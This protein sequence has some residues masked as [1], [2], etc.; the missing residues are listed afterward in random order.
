MSGIVVAEWHLTHDETDHVL[1]SGLE[2]TPQEQN[3]LNHLRHPLR[4]RQ[5]LAARRITYTILNLP[6]IRYSPNGTPTTENRYVSIAHSG[7]NIVVATAPFVV[8]I[9]IERITPRILHIASRFV[10]P[11]ERALLWDSIAYPEVMTL[12]WSFKE[13]AYKA[14]GGTA[15]HFQTQIRLRKWSPPNAE[16]SV[17]VDNRKRILHGKGVVMGSI[18]QTILWSTVET[19][20]T[21]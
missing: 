20:S 10:H 5:W 17:Q 1:R 9:D 6:P 3:M 16:V 14:T 2:L 15:P 21:G 11:S 8:G 7:T 18:V 13:A 19:T 12:L 4:R